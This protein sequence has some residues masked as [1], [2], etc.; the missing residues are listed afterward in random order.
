MSLE[1]WGMNM[2][3]EIE[4]PH[5]HSKVMPK[6]RFSS[7]TFGMLLV[8]GIIPF[9]LNIVGFAI[10]WNALSPFLGLL[11][12]MP[13][14]MPTTPYTPQIPPAIT[15]LLTAMPTSLGIMSIAN[16]MLSLIT[17]IVPAVVYWAFR[18]G[19]YKCP[20]CEMVI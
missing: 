2:V 13:T 16:L 15:D 12:M 5:C 20:I 14:E 11:K 10:L 8:L 9:I 6:H 3:K 19:T 4:C 1:T 17:G 18:H 7:A